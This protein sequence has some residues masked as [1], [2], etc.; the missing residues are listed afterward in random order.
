MQVTSTD[1]VARHLSKGQWHIFVFLL[2]VFWF[3]TPVDVNYSSNVTVT[4]QTMDFGAAAETIRKGNIGRRIALLSMA[5]MSIISLSRRGLKGLRPI[6]LLGYLLL[7]SFVLIITI[8]III[9]LIVLSEGDFDIGGF[10]VGGGS[11]SSKK[12]KKKSIVMK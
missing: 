12:E 7:F 8:I 6:G 9:V 5:G 4:L 11:S 10:S 1:A 2:A 3:T